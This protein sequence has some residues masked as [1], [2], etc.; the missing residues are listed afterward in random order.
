MSLRGVLFDLGGVVLGSPFEAIADYERERGLAPGAITRLIASGGTDSAWHE[1]ERGQLDV[2]EFAPRFEAEGLA[3]GLVLDGRALIHAIFRATRPR[4]AFLR[5][6]E[7]IRAQGLKA[8]A[9]TNNWKGDATQPLA[10][11]FDVFLESS[12]LGMRKPDPRIYLLACEKLELTPAE[13][14]FLD[15]IGSNLKPARELGMTTL[16][17]EEPTVALEALS[18]LLGFALT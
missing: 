9:L 10:A 18:K 16:K 15:D 5:A 4:P 3:R 1:L 17:V 14:V 2:S 12:K 13:V 7:L 11:H 8:A 6:I